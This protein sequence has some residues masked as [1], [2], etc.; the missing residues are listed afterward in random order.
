MALVF[1]LSLNQPRESVYKRVDNGSCL[2][3]TDEHLTGRHGSD[4]FVIRSVREHFRHTL[5]A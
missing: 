1:K 4:S 5:Y 2:R 3:V